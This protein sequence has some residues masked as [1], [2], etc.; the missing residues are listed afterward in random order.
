MTAKDRYKIYPAIGIAR[1][2]NSAEFYL[3]PETPG[4]LPILPKGKTV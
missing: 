2:G 4:G 1:V 3:E